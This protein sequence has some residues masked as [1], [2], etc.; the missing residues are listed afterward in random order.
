MTY[1]PATVLRV[2]KIID[3]DTFKC[4]LKGWPPIVGRDISIRIA[5]IDAPEMRSKDPA[6]KEEAIRCR[7]DLVLLLYCAKK[8]VLHNIKRGKY[9]RLIADVFVDGK[10][11]AFDLRKARQMKTTINL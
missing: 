8:I 9:F 5:G 2:T 6:V 4:N 1:G 3:G 11:L 10:S 7:E